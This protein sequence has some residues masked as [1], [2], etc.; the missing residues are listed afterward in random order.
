M[1]SADFAP[2]VPDGVAVVERTTRSSVKRR[3]TLIKK[4][5]DRSFRSGASSG[6]RVLHRHHA[7]RASLRS[8]NR[9]VCVPLS[10]HAE[11]SRISATSVEALRGRSGTGPK[12]HDIHV[13]ECTSGDA[14]RRE[15]CPFGPRRAPGARENQDMDVAVA[16]ASGCPR[17][18]KRVGARG[19]R[20]AGGR[21]ADGQVPCTTFSCAMPRSSRPRAGSSRTS[22]SRAGRSPTWGRVRLGAA[23]RRSRRSGSS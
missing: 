16:R 10:G 5:P 6:A 22:R 7:K 11:S 20:E 3:S 2:T 17:G 15:S 14:I 13:A 19:R 9:A 1:F 21:A 12:N 18:G 4:A 8:Q 23:A